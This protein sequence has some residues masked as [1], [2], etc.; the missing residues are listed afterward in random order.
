MKLQ[1]L[2]EL[3]SVTRPAKD[4]GAVSAWCFVPLPLGVAIPGV[5]R[6]VVALVAVSH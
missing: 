6:A 3:L 5:I 4:E 2:P 1:V